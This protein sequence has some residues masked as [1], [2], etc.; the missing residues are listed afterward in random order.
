MKNKLVLTVMVLIG[1]L[2]PLSG[3]LYIDHPIKHEYKI[4][5]VKKS[6]PAIALTPIGNDATNS[7][8]NINDYLHKY[9]YRIAVFGLIVLIG[10]FM[11]LIKGKD[12]RRR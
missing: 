12:R 8:E 11:N 2:M 10:F 4:E 7:G 6:E 3:M 1:L 5:N 9:R